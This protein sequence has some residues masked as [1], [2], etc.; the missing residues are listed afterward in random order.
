MLAELPVSEEASRGQAYV[1]SRL[2]ESS[3]EKKLAGTP[4]TSQI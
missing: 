4:F 3:V 1:I 2:A